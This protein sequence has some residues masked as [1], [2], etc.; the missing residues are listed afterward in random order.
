MKQI[1]YSAFITP[2]LEFT[3]DTNNHLKKYRVNIKNSSPDYLKVDGNNISF[4]YNTPDMY[5]YAEV[6]VLFGFSLLKIWKTYDVI[7][8]I[9]YGEKLK[10][11][12]S[13]N[14]EKSHSTIFISNLIMTYIKKEI[15]KNKIE[16]LTC[17]ASKS[18]YLIVIR[19]K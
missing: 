1:S 19:V 15:V 3:V 5:V 2:G 11:V 4:H 7:S 12:S 9:E 14:P 18:F 17:I 10:Y 16:Y 8:K 13:E 6:T